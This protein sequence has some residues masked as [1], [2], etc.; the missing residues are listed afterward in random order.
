MHADI[1]L[2][3]HELCAEE[4]RTQAATHVPPRPMR[5]QVGW[6]LVELGLHLVG[7][8]QPGPGLR[9]TRLA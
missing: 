1:H 8:Q 5:I 3:L 6:L 4:L 7:R 9:T 2:M